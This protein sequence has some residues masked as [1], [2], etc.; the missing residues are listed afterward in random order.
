MANSNKAP[1]RPLPPGT[2]VLYVR[3][4][5]ELVERLKSAATAE[6]R[7]LSAH[8]LVLLERALDAPRGNRQAG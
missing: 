1:K 7:S 4:P 3:A 6:R 5:E 8:A 2:A